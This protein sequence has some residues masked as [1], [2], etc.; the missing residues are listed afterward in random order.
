[1]LCINTSKEKVLFFFY[2]KRYGILQV[3]Y[4]KQIQREE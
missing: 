1:M 2:E 3:I 4:I